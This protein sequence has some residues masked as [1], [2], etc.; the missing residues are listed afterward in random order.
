ML[1]VDDLADAI[2]WLIE[3]PANV[4]VDEILLRPYTPTQA[5]VREAEFVRDVGKVLRS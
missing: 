4:R 2:L 3:R 5:T 1:Q